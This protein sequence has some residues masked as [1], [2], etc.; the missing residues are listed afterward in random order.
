MKKIHNKK[1]ENKKK[2][3]QQH[4]EKKGKKHTIKKNEKLTKM[5]KQEQESPPKRINISLKTWQNR[6]SN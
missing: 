6:R 1:N 2:R 5:R 4:N 3:I